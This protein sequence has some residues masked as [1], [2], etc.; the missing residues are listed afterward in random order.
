VVEE[1][2]M[3]ESV[4]RARG[5]RDVFTADSET[6]SNRFWKIRKQ[7]PWTL[8]ALSTHSSIEDIVVPVGE[9]PAIIEK[10]QALEKE[11]AVRIPV[12]GHAGD[13]NLHAHPLKDPQSTEAAWYELIPRL[14]SDLYTATAALGGTISGEHGIGSKRREF[15]PLVMGAG[16]I[17]LLRKIKK[18]MDP[19]G[20]LNPGKIFD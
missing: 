5:P 18:V 15:L 12:F 16:Q 2:A 17:D 7:V 8:K 14:L 11:Y 20:I 19:N 13:G 4:C 3:M 10:I 6:E 9:I 1:A